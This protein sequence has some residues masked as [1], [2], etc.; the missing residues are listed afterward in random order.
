MK[1]SNTSCLLDTNILVAALD[2][3]NKNHTKAIIFLTGSDK[4]NLKFILSSQNILELSAVLISALKISRK[5]SI[6]ALDKFINDPLVK[7][8]YPSPAALEKFISLLSEN[9]N[10]YIV[11]LFLIATALANNVNTVVTNDRDFSKVKGIKV[12]N[13]FTV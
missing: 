9:T 5:L 1:L 6:D 13:P 2:K 10:V 8:I 7:I 3:N 11:D 12:Y 4:A